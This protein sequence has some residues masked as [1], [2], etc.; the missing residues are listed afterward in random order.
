MKLK[1]IQKKFFFLFMLCLGLSLL[2]LEFKKEYYAFRDFESFFYAGKDILHHNDLYNLNLKQE[3]A[4]SFVPG[5][6]EKEFLKENSDLLPLPKLQTIEQIEFLLKT[7]IGVDVRTASPFFTFPYIYPPLLAC[8]LSLFV[9]LGFKETYFLWMSLS[10]LAIS[11]YP[12]NAENF[13]QKRLSHNSGLFFIFGVLGLLVLGFSIYDNFFWSQVNIFITSLLMISLN[14]EEK[15]PILAGFCFSF[16]CMV[17]MSPLLLVLYFVFRKSWKFLFFSSIGFILLFFFTLLIGEIKQWESF[18]QILSDIS[19]R[20]RIIRGLFPVGIPGN[21]SLKAYLYRTFPAD[22]SNLDWILFGIVFVLILYTLFEF[23]QNSFL[24]L[25]DSVFLYRLLLIMYISSP[26]AWLHHMVFLYPNLLLFGVFIYHSKVKLEYKI[27]VSTLFVFSFCPAWLY[28]KFLPDIT[29]LTLIN[30]LNSLNFL[31]LIVSF[32][33][34]NFLL[35]NSSRGLFF[36]N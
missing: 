35:S 28:V 20:D 30:Q 27:L 5:F 4:V 13:L 25:S 33:I 15:N 26:I 14:Y 8:V 22:F 21:F 24:E 11:L 10:F 2:V 23:V 29:N 32:F 7:V 18:F 16:A 17:K 6:L 9:N 12:L 1:S 31:F 3:I 19:D 34:P 36:K